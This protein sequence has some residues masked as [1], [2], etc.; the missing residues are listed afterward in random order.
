[1][2]PLRNSIKVLLG[3]LLVIGAIGLLAILF[4]L[5]YRTPWAGF[6]PRAVPPEGVEPAKTLWDWMEFL[7][8]P[9]FLAIIAIWFNRQQR[10]AEKRSELEQ[11]HREVL[12]SYLESMTRFLVDHSL[13]ESPQDGV[14]R[15][16]ARASTLSAIRRLDGKHRS[17]I[18]QFLHETGLIRKGQQVVDLEGADLQNLWLTGFDLRDANLSG[19][20]LTRATVSIDHEPEHVSFL[21]K[22]PLVVARIHYMANL[23]GSALERTR[24]YQARMGFTYLA[25]VKARGVDFRGAN[26]NR[27]ILTGADLEEAWFEGSNLQG[28]N[29]AGANLRNAIFHD[30]TGCFITPFMYLV[31]IVSWIAGTDLY[32]GAAMLDGADL[33]GADLRGATIS[34]KQ[35]ASARSLAGAILNDRPAEA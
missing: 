16:I 26:L 28:A 9:L 3:F 7:I 33:S 31:R 13:R 23:A 22:P 5:A 24:F 6:G 21:A 12:D 14:V 1:M 15:G 35:L 34:A 10:I 27:S 17:V 29:L 30:P 8:V 20:D 2:I 4:P 11:A 19:A 25:D 18:L 32:P